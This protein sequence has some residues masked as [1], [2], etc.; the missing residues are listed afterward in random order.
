M[1]LFWCLLIVFYSHVKIL[2]ILCSVGFR[3]SCTAQ[4]YYIY[5]FI[6]FGDGK[7]S[8]SVAICTIFILFPTQLST[9]GRLTDTK[10]DSE[11]FAKN[12]G[13]SQGAGKTRGRPRTCA[14]CGQNC[15][16]L[17]QCA[18]L[19]RQTNEWS[20]LTEGKHW[21]KTNHPGSGRDKMNIVRASWRTSKPTSLIWKRG[22]PKLGLH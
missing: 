10:L 2:N 6:Q 1:N 11:R 22:F 17:K 12:Q 14:F 21:Q 8:S 16:R 7:F 18:R 4:V 15:N 20:T 13:F 5:C 19:R 9:E 3:S